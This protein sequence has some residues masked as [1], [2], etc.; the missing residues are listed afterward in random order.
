MKKADNFKGLDL[1]KITQYDLFK[2][3]YPDFLPLIISYNSITENYTENDFRILDLLS[4]AENYQISDL[5]DKLKEV[6]EKSH[7]HLF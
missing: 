3:L 2:E 1:S 6:Y 5:A 7:P 4:F